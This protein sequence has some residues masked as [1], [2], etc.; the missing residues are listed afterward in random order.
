MKSL[1]LNKEIKY[2]GDQLSSHWILKNTQIRGDAIVSFIG[3]CD[4]KIQKMVDLED[5]MSDKAIFSESMLHFVIEHFDTDLSKTILRQRLF[6]SQIA[7]ILRLYQKKI[8]R[9]GDDLF[10]DNKK[11]S[12]SIATSSPVSSLIHTGLNI[13]SQ[14]TPVETIG[15]HDLK[16]SSQDLAE[17]I[18]ESYLKENQEISW[19]RSKVRSVI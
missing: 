12:V 9:R 16:I 11:L 3:S 1:F 17:K 14:N 18:M 2:T 5:V 4:V 10:I 7:E 19:A 13:S 8:E 15:L 6:I